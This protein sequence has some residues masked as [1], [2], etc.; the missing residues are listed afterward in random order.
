MKPSKYCKTFGSVTLFL[1]HLT[2]LA[3][4]YAEEGNYQRALVSASIGEI[5]SKMQKPAAHA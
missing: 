1:A 5:Q 2:H 3:G 4:C